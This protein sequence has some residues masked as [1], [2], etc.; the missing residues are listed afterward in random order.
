MVRFNAH[1]SPLLLGF[2]LLMVALVLAISAW[3]FFRTESVTLIFLIPAL[4]LV[5][6]LFSVK[7]YSID[8]NRLIIRKRGGW[9]TVIDLNELSDV[10]TASGLLWRSVSLW[11]S[12]GLFGVSGWIW[13]RTAG[14]YRA[15]VTNPA[16]M[17]ML[18]FR[19]GRKV[20]LSPDDPD[21]FL[22]GLGNLKHS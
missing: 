6:A 21:R 19:D 13:N 20:A 8:G 1:L 2:S 15:Y 14:I 10:A 22:E 5:V 11:S 17:V 4:F 18:E 16:N 9:Q 12:K 7:S 3:E